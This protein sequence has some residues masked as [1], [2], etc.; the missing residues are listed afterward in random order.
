MEEKFKKIEKDAGNEK[1]IFC[2]KCKNKHI[3]VIENV[4]EWSEELYQE[5]IDCDCT[6]MALCVCNCG[7]YWWQHT[8][9]N[10]EIK[11]NPDLCPRCQKNLTNKQN[12]ENICD[13]CVKILDYLKRKL[14][15][16][17]TINNAREKGIALTSNY[18]TDKFHNPLF[19]TQPCYLCGRDFPHYEYCLPSPLEKNHVCM[20]CADKVGFSEL[21]SDKLLDEL[22]IPKKF[23][24]EFR[25]ILKEED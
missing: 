20:D 24:D 7:L 10:P 3:L 12:F 19:T 16:K 17:K 11:Y 8:E 25:K 21:H 14:E 9:N 6:D 18:S 22:G 15:I 23:K 5:A 2:P 4:A 1:T 13:E